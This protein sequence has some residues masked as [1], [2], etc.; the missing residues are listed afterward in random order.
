V[1]DANCNFRERALRV[2]SPPERRP[3]ALAGNGAV[4]RLGAEW[5]WSAMTSPSAS[6]VK[7]ASGKD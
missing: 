5:R 6:F 7:A 3:F 1:P 4:A 2:D